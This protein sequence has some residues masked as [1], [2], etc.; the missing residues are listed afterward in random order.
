VFAEFQT[1]F[2]IYPFAGGE[3]TNDGIMVGFDDELYRA[4][5]FGP[6]FVK[7]QIC[8]SL[9]FAGIMIVGFE[10]LFVIKMLCDTVLL[11]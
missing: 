6:A 9:G 7:L 5:V 11:N 2:N 1:Y 3:P 10:L 8:P 4:T